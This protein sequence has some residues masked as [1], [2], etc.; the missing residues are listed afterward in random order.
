M[1]GAFP[2]KNPLPKAIAGTVVFWLGALAMAL[3]HSTAGYLLAGLAAAAAV[4]MSASLV[5]LLRHEGWAVVVTN[6]GVELLEPAMTSS[7][8]TRLSWDD[9]AN[10]GVAP[11]PPAKPDVLVFDVKSGGQRWVRREDLVDERL[12]AVISAVLL[13]LKKRQR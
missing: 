8:R 9:I 2:L 13:Q 10:V 12:E 1:K 7:K 3:T 11:A 5:N 6:D 4:V